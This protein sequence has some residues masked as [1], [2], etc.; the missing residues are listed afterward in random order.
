MSGHGIRAVDL[1]LP[2]RAG[3]VRRLLRSFA[4]SFYRKAIDV[5][6]VGRKLPVYPFPKIQGARSAGGSPAGAQAAGLRGFF[7]KCAKG[8]RTGRPLTCGPAA[9]APVNGRCLS[10]VCL[11][12]SSRFLAAV[13]MSSPSGRH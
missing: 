6:L 8:E 10:P 13:D 11:C 7:F 3:T 5:C 2:G 9:R 12:R 4:E 1:R